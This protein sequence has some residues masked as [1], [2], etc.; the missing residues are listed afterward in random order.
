MTRSDWLAACPSHLAAETFICINI[1][2]ISSKSLQKPQAATASRRRKTPPQAAAASQR[3]KPTPLAV[4]FR[5]H[6]RAADLPGG[7]ASRVNATPLL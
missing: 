1:K 3:R 4:A 5:G 7:S 2:D 6:H